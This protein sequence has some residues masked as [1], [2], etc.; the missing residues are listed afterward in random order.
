MNRF[1]GQ[2]R[3]GLNAFWIDSLCFL[4]LLLFSLR[5]LNEWEKG[6]GDA[7]MEISGRKVFF[8]SNV[9]VFFVHSWFQDPSISGAI[10]K[11]CFPKVEIVVVWLSWKKI[12]FKTQT[13]RREIWFSGL[14][15]LRLAFSRLRKGLKTHFIIVIKEIIVWNVFN[16]SM[17]C[18][19]FLIR[20]RFN[21]VLIDDGWLGWAIWP[22][23]E[24]KPWRSVDKKPGNK[25]DKVTTLFYLSLVQT[26]LGS[27]NMQPHTYVHHNAFILA[28]SFKY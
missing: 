8:L 5:W 20:I 4:L 7:T 9:F 21:V 18:H 11:F 27:C 26:Q 13:A 23:L 25:W 24:K 1:T 16:S 14:H 10:R 12:L 2:E 17:Y 15:R 3:N 22:W 28:P 19:N 6:G